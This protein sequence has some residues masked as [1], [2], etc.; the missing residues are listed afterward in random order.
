MAEPQDPGASKGSARTSALVVGTRPGGGLLFAH[1]QQ[2]KDGI[3]TWTDRGGHAK[4]DAIPLD[5]VESFLKM[6]ASLEE[7]TRRS[8]APA[9]R[10]RDEYMNDMFGTRSGKVI[11]LEGFNDWPA[12]ALEF[13]TMAR[14]EK[15]FCTEVLAYAANLGGAKIDP[16]A[17]F[18]LDDEAVIQAAIKGLAE[19]RSTPSTNPP[20]GR[21]PYEWLVEELLRH[22][23]VVLEGVA[24]SGKSYTV[25]SV[26]EGGGFAS[27]DWVVFHPAASYED[28]VEGLRPEGDTFSYT[29]GRFLEACIRAA[30]DRGE[31]EQEK[32]HLLVIDEINRANAARVLGDLLYCIEPGKRTRAEDAAAILASKAKSRDPSWPAGVARLGLPNEGSR[33]WICVPDNLYIIGT[34]NTTDRSVGSIDLALR[35]RFTFIR[36]PLLPAD[37]LC[38][39]VPD[40]AESAKAWERLNTALEDRI[41]PDAQLGHSYFYSAAEMVTGPQERTV[42]LWQ[43]LLLPQLVEILAAFNAF[44]HADH[45]LAVVEDGGTRW[46]PP[47]WLKVVGE[48]LDK[49]ALVVRN[50]AQ[51]SERPSGTTAGPETGDQ[52]ESPVEAAESRPPAAGPAEPDGGE[53]AGEGDF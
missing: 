39:D 33:G 51:P 40:L 16:T 25:E 23:N 47:Y 45:L 15:V 44:K 14:T 20:Q 42:I 7:S 8:L 38:R 29:E 3:V 5:S 30:G 36:Q 10:G 13:T 21:E 35:R 11:E 46:S 43:R 34:M 53:D 37:V 31:G 52:D 48:G 18:P 2:G 22:K 50:E 24:G 26:V 19:L 49:Y 12:M 27:T 28:F 41:G 17:V 9:G 4:A 1:R 6:V 32:R